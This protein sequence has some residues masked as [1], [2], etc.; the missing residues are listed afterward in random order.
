MSEPPLPQNPNLVLSPEWKALAN[1]GDAFR[2]IYYS[3]V[4][5]LILAILLVAVFLAAGLIAGVSDKSFDPK[6]QLVPLLLEN[7]FFFIPFCIALVAL[8]L[9]NL[10]V[11]FNAYFRFW[12]TPGSLVPGGK[13]ARI[14]VIMC[15]LGEVIGLFQY[16]YKET[17]PETSLM[18]GLLGGFIFLA[19]NIVFLVYSWRLASAINSQSIKRCIKW[20]VFGFLGMFFLAF[21]RVSE[22]AVVAAI[23]DFGFCLFIFIFYLATMIFFG[24]TSNDIADFVEDQCR[25]YAEALNQQKNARPQGETN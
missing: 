11:W 7:R 13:I 5:T 25:E 6:E 21:T 12:F 23:Q 4:I 9:F 22:I 17:A 18:F 10:F 14:Y 16:W 8:F 3:M 24:C 20:I 1:V 15:L 19:A 2:W